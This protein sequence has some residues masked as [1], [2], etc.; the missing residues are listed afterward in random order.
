MASGS[1]TYSGICALLPTAPTK[2]SRQISD[3]APM[4][5]ASTGIAAAISATAWKSS[6]PKVKKTRKMPRM[7]PQSPMRLTMNAFL[8]A[9]DALCLWYQKPISR[10]EQSPTPSHPTN[11]TRNV[12]PSTSSSMKKQNRLR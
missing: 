11:I 7:K 5:A 10:Y 8:P 2:S 3:S 1:Q 9:S 6:V 4:P 12:L